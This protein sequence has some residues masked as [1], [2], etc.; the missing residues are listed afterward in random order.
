[1]KR[2]TPI[3]Y[4]SCSI[5]FLLTSFV[6]IAYA[7][8]SLSPLNPMVPG[9]GISPISKN[10]MPPLTEQGM[11]EAVLGTTPQIGHHVDFHNGE[12]RYPFLAL[13]VPGVG[14]HNDQDM[15]I[16]LLFTYRSRITYNGHFGYN[17][18]F[19]YF[20]RVE[21]YGY[22]LVYYDGTGRMD[23]FSGWDS[24]NNEWDTNPAG[25]LGK[26]TK[27]SGSTNE[28]YKYTDEHGGTLTFDSEGRLYRITDRNG[29]HI[30]VNWQTGD[31]SWLID[32]ITDT[33]GRDFTFY[34]F[35]SGRLEK[36]VDFNNR[37]ILFDYSSDDDLIKISLPTDSQ[38]TPEWEFTYSRGSGTATLN[39]NLLTVEDP[40]GNTVL[41]NTY[42]ASSGYLQDKVKTQDYGIQDTYEIHYY[43]SSSKTG[44]VNGNAHRRDYYLHGTYLNVPEKLR[45]FTSEWSLNTRTGSWLSSVGSKCRTSDPVY[46]ETQWTWNS[47]RQMTK[48]KEKVSDTVWNSLNNSY[49]SKGNI[50]E[51]RFKADDSQANNDS[52]DLITTKTYNT[53][54][55]NLL[56]SVT[57]PRGN[58]TN[59]FYDYDEYLQS[60]DYNGD[61]HVTASSEIA[62]NLLRIE[63]PDVSNPAS[64]QDIYRYFQHE[65]TGQI[66]AEFNERGVKTLYEYYTANDYPNGEVKYF[67]KRKTLDKGTGTLNVETTFK[68]DKVGNIT[69]VTNPNGVTVNHEVND[70]NL[71]T[72]TTY[73]GAQSPVSA[74]ET[75]YEYFKNGNLKKKEVKNIDE[76]GDTG[77]NQYWS[78][79]Y[80]YNAVGGI[81]TKKIEIQKDVNSSSQ[82]VTY[83]YTYDDHYNLKQID[84]PEGNDSWR[85]KYD[86]RE[87][88]FKE[89]HPTNSSVYIQYDYN[90]NGTLKKKT[91]A[92]GNDTEYLY[93]NY[94][95]RTRI[96]DDLGDFT[97]YTYDK[98]TNVTETARYG[99]TQLLKKT[100]YSYD[101]LD[102]I[103]E[104]ERLKA[105]SPS[106]SYMTFTYTRDKRG[107][108]TEIEGPDHEEA[109]ATETLFSYDNLDR[110][111]TETDNEGNAVEYEYDDSGL[112]T[113]GLL[114]T[115]TVKIIE[116]QTT[117]EYETQFTYDELDRRKTAKV[118]NEENGSDYQLTTYHYDSM[119]NVVKVEDPEG[120]D[121]V[122]TYGGV[123]RKILSKTHPF[124]SVS[125][126]EILYAW[127]RNG[128]PT[129]IEDVN[130]NVTHYEYDILDRPEDVYFGYDG[131]GPSE[132]DLHIWFEFDFPDF[133]VNMS[134]QRGL[135]IDFTY[136]GVNLLTQVDITKPQDGDI[137][138]NDKLTYSYDGAYRL[139]EAKAYKPSTTVISEVNFEY[140]YLSRIT[141]EKQN[142]YGGTQREFSFEYSD[143][144]LTKITYPNSDEIDITRTSIGNI[145]EIKEGTNCLV[146]YDYWGPR[147]PESIDFYNGA[148]ADYEY[149]GYLRV[150]LIDNKDD[151]P[152]SIA[153]FEYGYDKVNNPSWEKRAGSPNKWDVYSYNDAY[154]LTAAKIGCSDSQGSNPAKTINYYF[155]DEIGNRSQRQVVQGSTTNTYY[156]VN[157]V[158]EYT[159]AADLGSAPNCV[160]YASS[161]PRTHDDV[162]NLTAEDLDVD[163]PVEFDY[164]YF[165]D[166]ANRLVRVTDGTNTIAEYDYDALGRRIMTD[167][168]TTVT[169]FYYHG[170]RV[171]EEYE[172]DQ[173]E[174]LESRYIHGESAA[175][176]VLIM[177]RTGSQELDE[178]YYF[179]KN[180]IG[181]TAAVT[182]G[183]GDLTEKYFYDAFGKV[184]IT[185][186][187][188]LGIA[189]SEID[190]PYLFTGRR[191]DEEIDK[192]YLRARHYDPFTGRFL[193]R[194]PMGYADGMNPYEYCMSNPVRFIDP[195]GCATGASDYDHV[196]SNPIGSTSFY[197]HVFE[198]DSVWARIDHKFDLMYSK[199][200]FVHWYM[201]EGMEDG[202]FGED[203]G[204]EE[205]QNRKK[206]NFTPKFRRKAFLHWYKGEGMDEMEF[207]EAES[208][209]NDPKKSF[210]PMFKRKAFLH[211]Y[212]GEGMDEMEFTEAESNKNP[213]PEKSFGGGFD[214]WA[215]PYGYFCGGSSAP[216]YGMTT[217]SPNFLWPPPLPPIWTWP[218]IIVLAATAIPAY[219]DYLTK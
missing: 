84:Y 212:L 186:G 92:R 154:K 209:K 71:V 99:S 106:E 11:K 109:G 196:V 114:E 60:T 68:Y 47:D 115:R 9:G 91:D 8:A 142:L 171:L 93:D 218:F 76:D 131:P 26:F 63:Y 116:G 150:D 176:D 163:D 38:V 89:I 110:K 136:N 128:N 132:Y 21:E 55:Y 124:D 74:Y 98:N 69:A 123:N 138:G 57:D 83:T 36:I 73:S 182:D 146:E 174:T 151:A 23:T 56:D 180:R 219:T 167:D 130:G 191:Y 127:D 52:Q 148:S 207:T 10:S 16:R 78:T 181:S 79:E 193:Q 37:E 96:T 200:A 121:T 87:L 217:L 29:N 156:C 214:R 61:S 194:D 112:G 170:G 216:E 95:R 34:Y 199:R 213:D 50:T 197:R 19:Y 64:Q 40:E 208:N 149:D 104:V 81:S 134:D 129:D 133:V 25:Y 189:S 15:D 94:G 153:K 54:Y 48:M 4:R 206:G 160:E 75:K 147:L 80:T 139:I 41:T 126:N 31:N 111:L 141:S 137:E 185:D 187:N 164:E 172:V 44:Y 158:N 113:S 159:L 27:D 177:M 108:I 135:E 169:L 67:L 62:G 118:I 14:G 162:G 1:M 43:Q 45:E 77:T 117:H 183:D 152:S 90:L 103:W 13:R 7:A 195:F 33:T 203:Y 161:P 190:N 120:N 46:F 88:K 205:Q 101:E 202:E 107:N 179:H 192:Y 157:D 201:G 53:D 66:K 51:V 65:S 97:T 18:D 70:W 12:F 210:K 144:G 28:R 17:W 178:Y 215:M 82:M 175:D 42:Y 211:W 140:D 72:K 122:F 184:Y 58:T 145:D 125:D 100:R 32:T 35:S 86:E 204:D 173:S 188:G 39:N 102:R 168:Q 155:K 5:S 30:E 85:T 105:T 49:D 3:R 6:L 165:Y 2:G 198:K 143:F 59:Y 24:A 20:K 22:D 119:G 166:Y